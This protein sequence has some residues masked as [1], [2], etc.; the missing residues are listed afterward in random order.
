MT[1][2]SVN[3]GSQSSVRVEYY[4]YSSSAAKPAGPNWVL[5]TILVLLPIAALT[6]WLFS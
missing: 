3:D 1:K 2:P 6:V 4:E 5:P